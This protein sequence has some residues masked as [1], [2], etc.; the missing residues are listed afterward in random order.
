MAKYALKFLVLLILT[1]ALVALAGA[2]FPPGAHASALPSLPVQGWNSYYAFHGSG[3]QAQVLQQAEEMKADGLEA[4][5]YDYINLD[6]GWQAA[7]RTSNGSLTWNTSEFPNG[8]PWLA[9]Q[10]HAMG[11]KFGLY[12]A[13]GGNTCLN[14]GALPGSYGHYQTDAFSFASWHADFVKVDDCKGLPAGTS[15]AQLTAGFRQFGSY[16]H[17]YGM[18]YSEELPVLMTPGST[19]W[20]SAVQA[21]SG[22]AD[23]WRVAP[24]ENYTQPAMTTILGHLADDVNL[25]GYAG[26]GHWNDLDMLVPGHPAG[27]P[28]PY[29]WTLA[30]EESQMSVWA[31]EASPLLVGANIANLTAAEVS[32]LENPDMRAVDQ[33]G[34]QSPVQVTHGNME[35]V[36][37]GADG[38]MSV[39]LVN[40]GTGNEVQSFTLAELHVRTAS[41]SVYNVWTDKL[42]ATGSSLEYSLAPGSTALLILGST[43]NDRALQ[44]RYLASHQK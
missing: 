28:Y 19:A 40:L 22:F 29:N 3:N 35:A 10:L 6:D 1:G 30:Q 4:A 23:M 27:S 11:F 44:A 42:S 38:G 37:K 15:A 5:G 43:A 26:P 2:L 33:S 39:L 18:V 32:A 31:E 36:V 34:S 20:L 17:Q 24:D 7:A 41:A 8:L 16:I 21:S 12:T 13:I 14:H 25:S 9:D